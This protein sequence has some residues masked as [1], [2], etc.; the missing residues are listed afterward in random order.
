MGLHKPIAYLSK[1]IRQNLIVVDG[2]MGDLNFEEGGNPVRMNRVLVGTDPV[3][4]DSYAADLLGFDVEDV[5]YIKMAENIGVG[6][7]D[8]SGHIIELNSNEGIEIKAERGRAGHF[9]KYIEERDACSA[10]YGSLVHALDRMQGRG[11]LSKIREKIYI[12]QRYKGKTLD[13]GIGIGNCTR[14]CPNYV[15]GCPPTARDILRHFQK[16]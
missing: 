5:P 2:I 16:I 14:G 6:K 9:T 1:A 13:S 12:G 7:T 8:W 15:A 3:M 4:M 10:C 11:Q